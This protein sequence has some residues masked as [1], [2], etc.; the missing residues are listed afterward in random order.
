[1]TVESINLAKQL[2]FFDP[3]NAPKVHVIGCGSV[4]STL[5][6]LVARAGFPKIVLWDNDIVKSHNVVNSMLYSTDC[7]KYKVD[8]VEE[9]IHKINPACEVI[10]NNKWYEGEQLNGIVLCCPDKIEVRKALF[11]ANEFNPYVKCVADFRTGLTSGQHVFAN[12]VN[13]D[14]KKSMWNS[15]DFNS[16]ECTVELTACGH[17]KG[18]APTVR[19][20]CSYGLANLINFLKGKSYERFIEADAFDFYANA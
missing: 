13:P 1:M 14:D 16:D 15:M 19:I 18:V 10:K 20:I 12:W 17:T 4:G 8:V 6:D 3:T 5:A 9:M 11:K 7:G 2:E